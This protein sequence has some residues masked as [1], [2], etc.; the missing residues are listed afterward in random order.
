MSV[1]IIVAAA[2]RGERFGKDKL[3]VEL[4]GRPLLA[5]TLETIAASVMFD[6]IVVV[7]PEDR[8]NSIRFL[9]AAA[10]LE[11]VVTAGG[12]R[13]QDSVL[14]GLA[15][16]AGMSQV[17]IH[18]A[19][20]PL[21]PPALFRSV[22]S[23]ARESDAAIVAIP[24]VDTIKRV[25]DDHVVETF[26]RSSLVMVQTPQAFNIELLQMAHEAAARNEFEAEDDA[27]LVERLGVRPRVVLGDRRNLKVTHEED[28]VLLRSFLGL[29]RV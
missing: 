15:E 4:D 3:W 2:G 22:V 27:S 7:A 29:A 14:R 26:D 19:A 5:H 24:A 11:L 8:W 17:V 28:L 21:C 18:D 20:R 9:G 10:D 6:R 23:A 1:G 16:C 25:A 13:R 12:E